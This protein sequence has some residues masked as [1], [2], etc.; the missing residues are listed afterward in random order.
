MKTFRTILALGGAVCALVAPAAALADPTNST[1]VDVH[2]SSLGYGLAVSHSIAPHTELRLSTGSFQFSHDGTADNL[3]YHGS[4]H[5]SNLAALV[6]LYPTGGGFR[7]SAGVVTGN[8]HIDV[9]GVPNAG[10]SFT[11]GNNT[12][13]GAQIGTVGGTA[14]LG[15]GVYVGI[16]N[17]GAHRAG[18]S[19]VSDVGVVFRSVSTNLTGSGPAAG[20]AQFQSDLAQAQT[21]FQNSVGVLKA[22]PVVSLGLSTRF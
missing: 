20:T 14:K 16:G 2:A 22:Y 5:L 10:G 6:D 7:V 15:S 3:D 13:T 4:V 17:G 11:I 19:L 1:S 9:T 18:I 12:Y 8:D 21:Q